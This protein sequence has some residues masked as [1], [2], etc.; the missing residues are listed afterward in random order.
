MSTNIIA[1]LLVGAMSMV[2]TFAIYASSYTVWS[3]TTDL[4]RIFLP[5]DIKGTLMS[6]SDQDIITFEPYLSGSYR[7]SI[8][9]YTGPNT[10]YCAEMC[11]EGETFPTSISSYGSYYYFESGKKYQLN[12]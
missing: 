2:A 10:I 12:Y 6:A 9:P 7:V 1:K 4:G 5:A 8:Y 3:A 11:E